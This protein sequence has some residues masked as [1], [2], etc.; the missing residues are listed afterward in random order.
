MPRDRGHRDARIRGLVSVNGFDLDLAVDGK[1]VEA[2]CCNASGWVAGTMNDADG[3]AR[4]F[5]WRNGVWHPFDATLPGQ[6]PERASTSVYWINAAGQLVGRLTDVEGSGPGFLCTPGSP[7][8][9]GEGTS[10]ELAVDGAADA[11]PQCVN[12]A[13]VVVGYAEVATKDGEAVRAFAWHG[14]TPVPITPAP[15]SSATLA[16]AINNA[17]VVIGYYNDDASGRVVGFLWRAGETV[18]LDVAG[19]THT[20]PSGINDA[21]QVVGHSC[22]AD[23]ARAFLYDGSFRSIHPSLVGVECH[24]TAIND[25]G[26]VVGDYRDGDRW[27][28]FVCRAGGLTPIARPGS[29]MTIPYMIGAGGMVVGYSTVPGGRAALPR[30]AR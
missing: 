21:G 14:T 12:A 23:G 9:P 5:L 7:E 27:I 6:P 1:S 17:G 8:R 2:A 26:D 29:A 16:I 28:G 24:A 30:S 3:S 11:I 15:G 4:G 19:A 10:V 18:I 20:Y 25:A 13:G 22:G